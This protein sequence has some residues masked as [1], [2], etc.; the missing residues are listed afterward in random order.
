[1][2]WTPIVVSWLSPTRLARAY[3]RF[4]RRV[5]REFGAPEVMGTLAAVGAGYFVHRWGPVAA[6]ADLVKG[7]VLLMDANSRWIG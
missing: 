4:V 5:V 6:A 3:W 1:M 7:V 2:R